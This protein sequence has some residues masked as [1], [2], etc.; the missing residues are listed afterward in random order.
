M[1]GGSG[2]DSP[3]QGVPVP[4]LIERAC[5]FRCTCRLVCCT[6]G[7]L[8]EWL[9]AERTQKPFGRERVHGR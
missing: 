4:V 6:P 5:A 8:S 7:S 9:S 3:S 2:G 1:G